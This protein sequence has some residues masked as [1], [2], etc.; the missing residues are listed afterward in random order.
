MKKILIILAIVF[1]I[2][3]VT[4]KADEEKQGIDIFLKNAPEEYYLD[5]LFSSDNQDKKI[6]LS[7]YNDEL[8][9]K[10]I[11]YEDDK[12]N[13]SLIKGSSLTLEGSLEKTSVSKNRNVHVFKYNVFENANDYYEASQKRINSFKII[14]VTKDEIKVSD[15]IVITAFNSKVVYDYNE[16]EFKV[17]AITA[18]VFSFAI[19]ISLIIAALIV[20]VLVAFQ[21]RVNSHVKAIVIIN[22]V[23]PIILTSLVGYAYYF[24]IF[25]LAFNNLIMLSGIY[26]LINLISSIFIYKEKKLYIRMLYALSGA[27]I[28][29]LVCYI[30]LLII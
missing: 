5:I 20:L 7:L 10:V 24:D 6:D 29:F 9:N 2:P 22:L 21:I 30:G 13:S 3:M 26:L 28:F 27:V 15:D 25:K 14:V 12:Y 17:Q 8:V 16:N 1:L 11:T 23:I 18:N 19:I 4:I